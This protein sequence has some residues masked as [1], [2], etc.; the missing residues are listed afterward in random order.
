MALPWAVVRSHR[1]SF[2][3][4]GGDVEL[5]L[6]FGRDQVFYWIF[7]VC[8]IFVRAPA[9]GPRSRF[10]GPSAENSEV[11]GMTRAFSAKHIAVILLALVCQDLLRATLLAS[12]A[13]RVD[14]LTMDRQFGAP[15][16]LASCRIGA[17][18]LCLDAR[19]VR[20]RRRRPLGPDHLA[21]SG[22]RRSTRSD[23]SRALPVRS[24]VPFP[25]A[26]VLSHCIAIAQRTFRHSP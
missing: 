8:W 4:V 16:D 10:P 11:I 12:P 24:V 21:V 5:R 7:D 20:W 2:L 1:R 3:L 26:K 15:S 25:R 22:L 18:T 13:A 19:A 9:A 14:A 6:W 23:L 17:E